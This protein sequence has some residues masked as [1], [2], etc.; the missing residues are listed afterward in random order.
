MKAGVYFSNHKDSLT[1]GR[2]ASAGAVAASGEPVLT[3]AFT[4]DSYDQAMVLE[5]IRQN[6]STSLIA[7]F[8]CAGVI[9]SS[10]IHRKGVGVMT[11]SGHFRAATILKKGLGDNPFAV[12]QS[13]GKELLASGINNGTAIVMPDGFQANLTEMLRGLYNEMG[14]DFQYIGGGAGDNL[15]FFKTYQFNEQGVADNALAAAVIEGIDFGVGVGHGWV[16]IGDPVIITR[17][18]GKRVYEMDGVPAFEEYSKRLRG[19]TRDQFPVMA[20]KHPLGFANISGEYIIRDPMKVNDDQSIDFVTEVP[21]QAVGYIMDGGIEVLVETAREVAQAAI[22][23]IYQ[24]EFMLLFDCISRVLLMDRRF[25]EE[26]RALQDIVGTQ[27]PLLGA[28]T[29]G[30]IGC[31]YNAPLFHNKTVVVAIGGRG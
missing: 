8:C 19:I 29:F 21:S 24:P 12:G 23:E 22:A 17:S 6:V 2:N 13:T 7:G 1:A 20:M 11:L 16:P 5:G 27:V 9:T 30:E 25:Q 3:L 26:I 28:L 18:N 15:N 4:T 10:G 31:Y 14:P